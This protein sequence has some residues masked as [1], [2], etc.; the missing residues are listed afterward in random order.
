MEKGLRLDW[1]PGGPVHSVDHQ[2]LDGFVVASGNPD[3]QNVGLFQSNLIIPLCT[4]TWRADGDWTGSPSLTRGQIVC[5]VG[6]TT[7]KYVSKTR[8]GVEVSLITRSR[9]N[10]P[11]PDKT[12]QEVWKLTIE[13]QLSKE[14]YYVPCSMSLPKIRIVSPTDWPDINYPPL[15]GPTRFSLV[16][17]AAVGTAKWPTATVD[18]TPE[19]NKFWHREQAYLTSLSLMSRQDDIRDCTLKA[20]EKASFTGAISLENASDIIGA[21]ETAKGFFSLGE[22]LFKFIK[23]RNPLALLKLVAAAHLTYRYVIKTTWKDVGDLRRLGQMLWDNRDLWWKKLSTTRGRCTALQKDITV[24]EYVYSTV[25]NVRLDFSCGELDFY[26][27]LRC[28]GLFF[29]PTDLW[30]IVPLSFA[31]DWVLPVGDTI[32]AWDTLTDLVKIQNKLFVISLRSERPI[33]YT[34]RPGYI[35][36][37]KAVRFQRMVSSAYVGTFSPPPFRIK[38][39]CKE[40]ATGLALIASFL[41]TK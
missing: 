13:M 14:G 33:T 10:I 16:L 30:N 8:V 4:H 11:F 31:V 26:E 39:P 36:R 23:T 5:S 19:L 12:Y 6:T 34:L 1:G 21:I 9:S 40:F 41:K 27:Y 38:N 20:V 22:D 3:Y 7:V 32:S 15:I 35:F 2:F 17:S 24:R 18:V 25:M 37:G 29:R 28:T